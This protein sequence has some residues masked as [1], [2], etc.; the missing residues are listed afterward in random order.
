MRS[1]YVFFLAL[2]FPPLDSFAL[3]ILIL[4]TLRFVIAEVVDGKLILLGY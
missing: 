4:L 2:S 1:R 3:S